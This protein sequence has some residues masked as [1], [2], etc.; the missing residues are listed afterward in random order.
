M[1]LKQRLKARVER[2]YIP[3]RIIQEFRHETHLLL[4]RARNRVTPRAHRRALELRRLTDVKLN[5]GCGTHILPGWLNVDGW[6]G[7][8]VAFVC[9]LRQ[10]LPLRDGSCRF[11]FAEHVFEHIDVQF[12]RRVVQEWYRLLKRDG[13]LRVVGP[14]CLR[15]AQAYA[16]RDMEW[17]HKSVPGCRSLA[18]GMND[19]FK[20]YFHRY[21][22]DVESLG[23]E[24]RAAGFSRLEESSHLGSNMLELRVD[25]AAPSRIPGNL[26]V[27]A[28]K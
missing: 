16:R 12:R 25:S 11:I 22:D 14:D 26:Y 6:A 27:E 17:F 23:E 8:G 13:V 24:L 10:P 15:F 7:E 4:V 28:R 5:F 3:L 18:D 9:D 21:L 1:D 19:I 20:N 2:S